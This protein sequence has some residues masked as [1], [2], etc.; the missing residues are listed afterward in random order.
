VAAGG[1]ASVYG[2]SCSAAA[3]VAPGA[4]C[5]HVSVLRQAFC[6]AHIFAM[7][8]NNQVVGARSSSRCRLLPRLCVTN[9]KFCA[10]KAGMPALAYAPPCCLCAITGSS[11]RIG[12]NMYKPAALPGLRPGRP[13]WNLYTAAY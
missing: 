13:K 1:G 11:F 10:S 4:N 7:W 8:C 5:T 9:Y 12:L 3:G 6:L 2:C